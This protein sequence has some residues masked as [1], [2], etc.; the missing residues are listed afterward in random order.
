[1]TPKEWQAKYNLTDEELEFVRKIIK[2]FNG[3]VIEVIPISNR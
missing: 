2:I 1:M 3:K